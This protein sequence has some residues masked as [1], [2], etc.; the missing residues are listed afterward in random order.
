MKCAWVFAPHGADFLRRHSTEIRSPGCDCGVGA[1]GRHLRR[2]PRARAARGDCVSW[3]YGVLKC[4]L[5][6][7]SHALIAALVRDE[8]AARRSPR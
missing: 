5:G 7:K 8:A 3:F 4:T 1:A 2:S 6:A